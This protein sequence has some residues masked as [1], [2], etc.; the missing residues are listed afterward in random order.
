MARARQQA[1]RTTGGD[2]S[3]IMSLFVAMDR[4]NHTEEDE[5]DVVA[6]CPSVS[7][8]RATSSRP[9]LDSRLGL[10]T[11]SRTA[12]AKKSQEWSRPGRFENRHQIHHQRIPAT[13]RVVAALCWLRTGTKAPPS[14]EDMM[15][16]AA[17]TPSICSVRTDVVQVV[18][19]EEFGR[20]P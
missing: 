20:V 3:K 11:E 8:P 17:R 7:R 14:Y 10:C 15:V 5:M 16:S 4:A 6:E 12:V 18:E 9:S 2:I 1:G 13:K 19:S